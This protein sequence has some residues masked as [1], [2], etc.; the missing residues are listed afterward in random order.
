MMCLRLKPGGWD[1]AHASVNLGRQHN[2]VARSHIYE[3][4]SGDFFAQ[5][6]RIDVG[7]IEE[8]NST[9]V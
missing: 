5:V 2:I 6:N 3:V 9:S 7:S 4:R 1:S 8:I